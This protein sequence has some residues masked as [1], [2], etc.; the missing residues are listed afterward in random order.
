MTSYRNPSE[1]SMNRTELTIQ[2]EGQ[3][4]GIPTADL[5]TFV[6]HFA[7]ILKSIAD[8]IQSDAKIEWA[9][10]AAKMSSPLTLTLTAASRNPRVPRIVAKDSIEGLT[11]IE[12][13]C[14]MPDSMSDQD[15]ISAINMVGVLDRG[16]KSIVISSP[17]FGEVRP[18]QHLKA[19]AIS[20]QQLYKECH[21]S[22]CGT[23]DTIHIHG[24]RHDFEIFDVL[25]DRPVKCFFDPD[26]IEKAG[27][28]VSKRVIVYGR[29]RYSVKGVPLAIYVSDFDPIPDAD[30]IDIF[31]APG[32]DITSGMD[33]VE[34]VRKIR[35]GEAI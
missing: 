20:I 17:E 13:K 10:T 32:I 30:M 19:N 34:Y 4:G 27:A 18:T 33:A 14:Q 29:V 24:D 3:D 7:G 12:K 35:N 22:L 23:L 9:I 28:L 26:Q 21:S 15:L 8:H 2:L 6:N 1:A 11:L 16:V 31:A 25:T 5:M